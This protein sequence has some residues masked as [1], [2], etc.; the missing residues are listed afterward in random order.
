MTA[1]NPAGPSKDVLLGLSV[2]Q[3]LA[4]EE[5]TA[6]ARK[7]EMDQAQLKETGAKERQA[8][9]IEAQRAAGDKDREANVLLQRRQTEIANA[10]LEQAQRAQLLKDIAASNITD[11]SDI[12]AILQDNGFEPLPSAPSTD[13]P[14]PKGGTQLNPDKEK[15]FSRQQRV[16]EAAKVLGR[17]LT[18]EEVAM[19]ANDMDKLNK[20]EMAALRKTY[21]LPQPSRPSKFNYDT[22]MPPFMG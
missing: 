20:L 19:I 4:A 16:V 22:F 18:K 21:P 14:A 12:N 6:A 5:Q 15:E 13:K 3:R 7:S 2:T 9:L 11:P 17:D 10:T 8:E 1:A